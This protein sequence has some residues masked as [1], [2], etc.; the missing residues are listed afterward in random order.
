MIL[1]I[2]RVKAMDDHTLE[3]ELENGDV[4]KYDMAFVKNRTGDAVK[5]LTDIN[6]FKNVY[7]EHGAL[8]WSC[9]YGI[10]SNT[11]VRDGTL[12][13]KTQGKTRLG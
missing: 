9:G 5:P 13:S 4:Y 3:C 1:D 2:V 12:I 6:I 10:H 11:I 7:I 8:E